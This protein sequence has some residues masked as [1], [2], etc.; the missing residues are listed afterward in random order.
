MSE[1]A[2]DKPQVKLD[3]SLPKQT[4]VRKRKKLKDMFPKLFGLRCWEKADERIK[5]GIALE[6]VAR[7]IQDDMLEYRDSKRE[8]LVRALYRYKSQVQELFPNEVV[9]AKPTEVEEQIKDM[10]RNIN[11]LEELEKLYLLQLK[12]IGM[13]V[14]TETQINK[15]FK[16]TN[17]E[18]QTAMGI[19]AKIAELKMKTGITPMVSEGGGTTV[20]NMMIAAP[21]VGPELHIDEEKRLKLGVVAEKLISVLTSAK[22]DEI[23]EVI[24]V[25]PNKTQ[26]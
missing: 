12:R 2:G 1:T 25:T 6:E 13:E 24:D 10:R 18:I 4:G 3:V 16:T 5:A 26:E 9:Q 15:L 20:N 21:T 14:K 11:E 22:E 17:P 7:W 8:S 19:L 23:R